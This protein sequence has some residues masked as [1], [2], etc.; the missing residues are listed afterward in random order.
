LMCRFHIYQVIELREGSWPLVD[1]RVEVGNVRPKHRYCRLER[2]K[3]VLDQ[4][5]GLKGVVDEGTIEEC[6]ARIVV[7]DETVWEDVRYVLKQNGKRKYYN[8][9]PYII[10]RMGFSVLE[11]MDENKYTWIL[12]DFGKMHYEFNKTKGS[13]YFPNLRFICFKLMQFYG[14]G[15]TFKVPLIRTLRKKERLDTLWELLRDNINE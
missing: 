3:G 9:I 7:S 12:E 15:Y 13:L 4:L 2:F 10:S 1:D 14:I 5:L 11:G 8:R 6:K